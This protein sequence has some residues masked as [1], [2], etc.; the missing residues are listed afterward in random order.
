[1]KRFTQMMATIPTIRGLTTIKIFNVAPWT[2]TT[3]TATHYKHQPGTNTHNQET[4]QQTIHTP[5]TDE[6]KPNQKTEQ[7]QTTHTRPAKTDQNPK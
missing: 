7:Q 2:R 6:T 1:M 3:T 4:V 5:Q